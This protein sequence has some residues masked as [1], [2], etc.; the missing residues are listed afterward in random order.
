MRVRGFQRMRSA[1]AALLLPALSRNGTGPDRP[2]RRPGARRR[3]PPVPTV[4][5]DPP[6]RPSRRRPQSRPER[7]K[8]GWWKS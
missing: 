6:A 5:A 3:D 1:M 8:T 2:P 4:T 7:D